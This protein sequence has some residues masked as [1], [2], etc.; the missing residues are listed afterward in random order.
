MTFRTQ[1]GYF[2]LLTAALA[3]PCME[4][5]FDGKEPLRSDDGRTVL[6]GSATVAKGA[7]ITG[8][9][10]RFDGSTAGR[11]ASKF[12]NGILSF[13]ADPG[14]FPGGVMAYLLSRR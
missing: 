12:E 11:V 14:V 6:T 4:W 10:L 9:A 8:D 13:T 3:A 2:V 1:I 5:S 7:G